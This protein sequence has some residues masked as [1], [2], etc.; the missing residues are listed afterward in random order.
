M[1]CFGIFARLNVLFWDILCLERI[2]MSKKTD[3]ANNKYEILRNRDYQ[4]PNS[5]INSIGSGT[6]MAQK[7]FAV[8][9]NYVKRDDTGCAVMEIDG[10]E[11]KKL[12]GVE[13]N[14]LYGEI[15][16]NVDKELAKDHSSI[17]DWAILIKDKENNKL[18]ARQV[19]TDAEFDN[20]KL[21]LRYNRIIS[22][23]IIERK[24]D[25][26]VL[27]LKEVLSLGCKYSI[28]LY[29][30]LKA[31]FDR[32]VYIEKKKHG[33][34]EKEYVFYMTITEIKFNL[35]VV[36]AHGDKT[37]KDELDKEHPDYDKIEAILDKNG[38]NK[39]KSTGEFM[40]KCVYRTVNELNEYTSLHVVTDPD[41]EGRFYK[42]VYFYVSMKDNGVVSE[43]EEDD[44]KIAFSRDE[45]NAVLDEIMNSLISKL[46]FTEILDI[47]EYAN[48][49]K[50]KIL[51]AFDYMIN[52]KGS[53]DEPVAFM[54]A[55][56]KEGWADKRTVVHAANR[57]NIFEQNH[58]DYDELEKQ[59]LDN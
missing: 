8:G 41:K 1:Y 16:K 58:Y 23:E 10:D 11:L 18:V 36:T 45:K 37:I 27:N 39:Y 3:K 24:G 42:G 17:F 12:F 20:G 51:A 33:T 40:R 6:K 55:A 34:A 26:T 19:I 53:V 22:D 9:M 32:K 30:R 38:W 31:A 4:K 57:F 2:I 15:E 50:D 13:G 25:Y 43:P 29:E 56:I 46:K 21:I 59:L 35:G 28:P 52:Y 5:M 49:N 44:V 14:S 48:Y 54:K 47:C 7:L